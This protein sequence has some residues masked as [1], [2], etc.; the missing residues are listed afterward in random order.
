MTTRKTQGEILDDAGLK[1]RLQVDSC[2][3][4]IAPCV[5]AFAGVTSITHT[6]VL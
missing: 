3:A 6:K 1:S 2:A 4:L 5:S